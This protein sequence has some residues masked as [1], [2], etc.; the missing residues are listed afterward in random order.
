[1]PVRRAFFLHNP[2]RTFTEGHGPFALGA[3]NFLMQLNFLARQKCVRLILWV[4]AGFLL[5]WGLA[6][7]TAPWL[8]KNQLQKTISEQLGRRSTVGQ[9]DFRP[10]TL[11]L[12]INDLA[13]AS[14][15]GASSQFQLKRIYANAEIESLFRLAPVV[16]T[17]QLEGPQL[18]LTR[19][20]DGKYDI[21]DVLAR[22]AKRDLDAAPDP[23]R[24]A[25]FNLSLSGGALDFDDHPLQ[26]VH[27]LRDLGLNIPFLSNLE[28]KRDI[29]VKPR[30]A[31]SFNGSRFDS[32]AQSTPF[33]PSQKTDASINLQNFDLAPYLPYIPGGLPV[34]VRQAM[35]DADLKLAFE[36]AGK[37]VVK[38]SG[39]IQLKGVKLADGKSQDL[40][41]FD[42]LKLELAD[43]RPLD[44]VAK[45]SS[46]E[47]AAPNLKVQRDGSG[48]VNLDLQASSAAKVSDPPAQPV[49]SAPVPA[50]LPSTGDKAWKVEVA[51]FVLRDGT[52]S[53]LDN[54][55]SP[56]ARL[57]A[58]DLSIDAMGIAWPLMQ[59]VQ[60][61]GALAV[62][63]AASLARPAGDRTAARIKFGG[64]AT[65]RQAAVMVSLKGAALDLAR[66]YL[67][68]FLEPSLRGTLAAE[69]EVNWRAPDLQLAI[70]TL[71]L[72]SERPGLLKE[73]YKR[74]DIVKP[75]NL[76]GLAKDIPVED[77]E[78]L[79]LYNIQVTGETM[80]EL[81]LQR[82]IAVKDYPGARQL[83]VERLFLGSV[84]PDAT[85][86]QWS[87]RAELSLA[88]N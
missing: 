60:F 27:H 2:K 70:R 83:S 65:E 67:A 8:I 40:L 64:S 68:S 37:P 6:W 80:Q 69:L 77:M 72:A 31:F 12:T 57:L 26:R 88:N 34:Q 45:F 85:G 48:R 55:I 21:D 76:V 54:T 63:A 71:T 79:L 47:L 15:D 43:V 39:L 46:I 30:L 66:P 4:L 56:G 53:W 36:Q 62:G 42:G 81:A 24:F 75:R 23:L 38:L 3:D 50:P 84:K 78:S 41:S 33:A 59:P 86:L 35:L 1:V 13:I 5:V 61:N 58:S 11:E 28:S 17:L 16:E 7:L 87:P 18:K 22:L 82:G 73:V 14:Q 52:A 29:Q 19:L 49:A 74:A 25:L 20:G 51:K 9:I 10:W 44:Q 32:S